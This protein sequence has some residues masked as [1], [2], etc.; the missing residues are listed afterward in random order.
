VA[1]CFAEDDPSANLGGVAQLRLVPGKPV[2]DISGFFR[3][4]ARSSDVVRCVDSPVRLLSF[5]GWR[6]SI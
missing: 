4:G 1:E 3:V 5:A 6:C 2:A